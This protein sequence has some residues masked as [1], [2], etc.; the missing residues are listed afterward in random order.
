MDNR[1]TMA[2]LLSEAIKQGHIEKAKDFAEKL[3]QLKLNVAVQCMDEKEPGR[4]PAG[5]YE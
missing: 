5:E 3:A 1:D 4:L 2:Q